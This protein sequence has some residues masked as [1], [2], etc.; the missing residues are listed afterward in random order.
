MNVLVIFK[1]IPSLKSDMKSDLFHSTV[2]GLNENGC[3]VTIY[4]L[5]EVGTSKFPYLKG[6]LTRVENIFY[7]LLRLVSKRLAKVFRYQL[8]ARQF[9]DKLKGNIDV[10]FA[11]CTSTSPMIEAYFL[12]KKLKVPYVIREHR[13]CYANKYSDITDLQILHRISLKKANALLAVSEELKKD[14]HNIGIENVEAL[15][16]PISEDFFLIKKYNNENYKKLV[17]W[18]GGNFLFGAW[19]RW[20]DMKRIDVLLN[21]YLDFQ[22]KVSNVKL[23]VAGPIENEVIQKYHDLFEYDFKRNVRFL[24]RINRDDIEMLSQLIDCLVLSS[25]YET[26]GLPIIEANAKGKPAVVTNCGGPKN[27]IN[28]S[29]LGYIVEKDDPYKLSNGMQK[30]YSQKEKYKSNSKLISDITYNRYSSKKIG[31]KLID[32]FNSVLNATAKL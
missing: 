25:N 16:N 22:K 14:M 28:D 17:E 11:E 3:N 6:K 20:R 1:E 7:G 10:I 18:K 30:I 15:P 9:H 8:L 27:I 26:F 29:R 5:G 24:G 32:I 13:S 19:T 4:T 23:I 31:E 21:A 2:A 12:S